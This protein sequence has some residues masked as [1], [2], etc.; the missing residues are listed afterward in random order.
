MSASRSHVGRRRVTWPRAL[1]SRRPRR[2]VWRVVTGSRVR[3][4]IVAS[5]VRACRGRARAER[6]RAK[7][8]HATPRRANAA[9]RRPPTS[10]TAPTTTLARR[11]TPASRA[12]VAAQRFSAGTTATPARRPA[13]RAATAWPPPSLM[14]SP[15]LATTGCPVP[16]AHAASEAIAPWG[17]PL[18]SRLRG[19]ARSRCAAPM[20]TASSRTRPTARLVPGPIPAPK[21]RPVSPGPVL[22]GRRSARSTP[23]LASRPPA[24]PTT[25]GA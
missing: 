19:A 23:R 3:R 6:H 20:A 25:A 14:T 12:S 5:A 16:P 4:V 17:S 7:C 21:R 18:V 1:A 10:P 24:I 9:S 8:P 11:T 13:V 2:T 22:A 15:C